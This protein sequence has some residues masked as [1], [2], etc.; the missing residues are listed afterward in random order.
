MFFTV[1]PLL[2]QLM[3]NEE[4]AHGLQHLITIKQENQKQKLDL[5]V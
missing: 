1:M 4:Y 2:I 5:E 3:Q